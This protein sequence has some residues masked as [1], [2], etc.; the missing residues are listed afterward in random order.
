MDSMMKADE[1][2]KPRAVKP[3]G[4][5]GLEVAKGKGDE[6]DGVDVTAVSEGGPAA[7]AGVKAGDRLLTVD[8][9]WTD[10]VGD[11]AVATSLVKAGKGVP[12]V[13]LRDGKEVTLT[14]TPAVGR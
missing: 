13:L 12:V 8:G 5:W 3:A 7:K 6:K 10:S 2:N 11:A 14:V 9:R 4:V 1:K